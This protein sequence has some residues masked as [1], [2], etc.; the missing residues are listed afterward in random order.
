MKE[1][2]G[3]SRNIYA[4]ALFQASKFFSIN[5]NNVF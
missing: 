1:C 5:S 3:I 4:Y 2:S